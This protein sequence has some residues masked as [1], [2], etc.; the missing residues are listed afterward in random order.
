M[1][2]APLSQT[3]RFTMDV[4]SFGGCNHT[5]NWCEPAISVSLRL[6]RDEQS[7]DSGTFVKS[8]IMEIILGLGRMFY[9]VNPSDAMYREAE[10]VPKNFLQVSEK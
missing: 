2:R 10:D 6:L 8:K 1:F 7:T 5:G 9:I 3:T 4:T